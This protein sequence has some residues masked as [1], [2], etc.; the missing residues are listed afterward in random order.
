MTK[1]EQAQEL[2]NKITKLNIKES[3]CFNNNKLLWSFIN[4]RKIIEAKLS[5]F[6]QDAEE[7]L[8]FLLKAKEWIAGELGYY[9]LEIK[10]RI[11]DLKSALEVLG[12][13]K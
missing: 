9:N 5:Q 12:E 4:E 2:L 7:E 13:V 3:K 8:R 11:K 10:T 6:K 1:I